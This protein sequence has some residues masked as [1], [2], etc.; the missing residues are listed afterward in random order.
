[1]KDKA[2]SNKQGRPS[3]M[4]ANEKDVF[5]KIFDFLLRKK[6]KPSTYDVLEAFVSSTRPKIR[7]FKF[8]LVDSRTE[9][10]ELKKMFDALYRARHPPGSK[11]IAFT[12]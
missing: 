3:P 12:N 1:V 9:Q 11:R 7:K 5:G 2:I 8:S 4:T 6:P 10:A